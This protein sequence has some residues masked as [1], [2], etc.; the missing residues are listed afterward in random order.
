MEDKKML[1][2]VELEKV[3]GGAKSEIIECKGIVVDKKPNGAYIVEIEN[4]DKI[5]AHL[6]GKH[7]LNN[8]QV[9]VGDKVV[10]EISPY[11]MRQGRITA[12]SC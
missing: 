9:A 7:L 6:S 8:I 4:G 2:D 5:E 3:S 10:V 1:N 12:R 11:G